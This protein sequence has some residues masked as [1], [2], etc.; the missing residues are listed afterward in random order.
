MHFPQWVGDYDNATI[1]CNDIKRISADMFHLQ[2][3][4]VTAKQL[5]LLWGLFI[6]ELQTNACDWSK[7]SG[8]K[9]H[10]F[11]KKKGWRWK[12]DGFYNRIMVLNTPQNQ[13]WTTS[14]CRLKVPWPQ[15]HWKS[16]DEPQ[17]RR[18][19]KTAQEP[20]RTRGF[21]HERMEK[22]PPNKNWKTLSF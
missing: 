14:R 7:T 19:C 3:T 2:V 4:A 5:V 21:L 11:C 16:V 13:Q 1:A 15:H 10:T 20:Y 8:S 18:A 22:N 12:E 9:H 17:K 6:S